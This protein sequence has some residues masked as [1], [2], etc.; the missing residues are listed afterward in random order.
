MIT[1]KKIIFVSALCTANI[2]CFAQ[3]YKSAVCRLGEQK[4]DS[5][6]PY[7]DSLKMNCSSSD[8]EKLRK[9]SSKLNSLKCLILNGDANSDEWDELFTEIKRKP[10]VKTIVFDKNSFSSLPY[11]FEKLYN[12]EQLVISNN[13][14]IDYYETF[15]Q[16]SQLPNLKEISLDIYSVFDL[17]DSLFQLKNLTKIVL[18]N[19]EEVDPESC[20]AGI[21]DTI[22]PV[23]FDF[24]L[25]KGENN[26]AAVKYTCP[27]GEIDSVEYSELTRRFYTTQNFQASNTSSN[28]ASNQSY[29]PKYNYVKP[30]IAGLDV[31]RKYYTINPTVDNVM[32][33]PSG[34]KIL[35]PANSFM[36]QSG[37]PVKGSVLINYREFRDPVDFLVSGIPM[38]YDSGGVIN[39]FESAGMFEINASVNQQ[40]LKLMPGKQIKMNFV[41]T[42]AD[43][44]YNFYAFNDSSGNW[45][46]INKPKKVTNN[47]TINVREMS[48]ACYTYKLGL[49]NSPKYKDSTSLNGRFGSFNYIYSSIIDK[50]YQRQKYQFRHRGKEYSKQMMGL[51][52]LMHVKKAKDGEILFQLKYE[53]QT[54]PEMAEFRHVYFASNE[55]LSIYQFKKRYLHKQLFNDVRIHKNGGDVEIQL[56][57]IN[58]Y[59]VI[60]AGVVTRNDKGEVKKAKNLETKIKRYDRSLNN[61]ER[62]FKKSIKNKRAPGN[63][64][65]ITDPK[66]ISLLAFKES[67]K[68]MTP[69]EKKMSYDEW[70]IYY[71]QMMENYNQ[72]MAGSRLAASNA[73]A[74]KDNLMCSLS[75]DGMGIYNCDQIQRLVDPVEIFASYKNNNSDRFSA[76]STYII[77]KK[78]NAVLQYDGHYGYGPNNIAFS[79]NSNAQNVLLAVNGNGEMAIYK[80][81]DFKQNSFSNN[82]RFSFKVQE[83][84]GKVKTVADLKKIIGL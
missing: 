79:N 70:V 84:E 52:R 42:S 40:P 73:V 21:S 61:R 75:L 55:K 24:F 60:N 80:T 57:G 38:K 9:C 69:I 63:Y 46:Y 34:T 11:G 78:T 50:N 22:K 58:D 59:K 16:L 36:D 8:L 68:G 76:K 14:E 62:R 10:A 43:S 4:N 6:L 54:H 72:M 32:I 64:L 71:N 33:Y 65:T 74:A 1:I 47:T 44:T 23:T 31:E 48:N 56:K 35:I 53:H 82:S 45:E 26:F 25:K 7:I 3:Q 37:N 19:K 81:E 12:I 39:N 41:S 13:D 5:L 28:I 2:F 27:A 18:T 20:I 67:K 66:Q 29:I 15:Q 30:P 51:I 77:D 17:P 83:M 49:M